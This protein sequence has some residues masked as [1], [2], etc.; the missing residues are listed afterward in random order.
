MSRRV[1]GLVSSPTRDEVAIPQTQARVFS[2]NFFMTDTNI[3]NLEQRRT[4]CPHHSRRYIDPQLLRAVY[5]INSLIQA[6]KKKKK[7][8]G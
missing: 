4:R 8:G 5:P 2:V 7:R 1:Q 6:K 3:S